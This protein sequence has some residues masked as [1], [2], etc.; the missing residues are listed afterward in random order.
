MWLITSATRRAIVRCVLSQGQFAVVP[1][2]AACAAA[3]GGV[4]APA[5]AAEAASAAAVMTAAIAAQDGIS[6]RKYRLP[7][8]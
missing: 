8:D 6:S 2:A 1:V 7:N 3:A 5:G 4:W